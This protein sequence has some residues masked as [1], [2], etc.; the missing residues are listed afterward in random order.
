MPKWSNWSGK[1]PA[2]PQSLYHIRSEE[3]ASAIVAGANTEG[4]TVRIAG[5]GHSHMPLVANDDTILD[6][7]GLAGVIDIDAGA[8]TARV[9][10]GTKIHALGRPLHDA[11]LAL[12]NQGDIDRQAIAGVTATGTHG[13]GRSLGNLSALVTGATLILASGK[14]IDCSAERH[15]ATWAALRLNLGAMGVITQ[16]ELQLR[17]AYKLKESAWNEEFSSLVTRID[18]LAGAHR[19][20][21]FFWSPVDDQAF[22]KT[23]DE[24]NDPVVYPLAE[25]GQRCAWSYEVFP[26]HRPHL[27]TEMEYSVPEEN[28][29]ACFTAIRDLV[30]KDFPDLKWP[31]E[32]R[33]VAADDV[34]LSAAYERAT[35]TISVHQDIREDD[36]P[37]FRA[38]EK[39]FLS[40]GGRPHWGKINYLGGGAMRAVH[41]KWDDWWEIRNKRDPNGI[42]LNDLLRG[43][44]SASS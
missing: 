34:W 7:S 30:H 16:L 37:L 44:Q 17:D 20:F 38:C 39:V 31:V 22:A 32:Y 14:R 5:S 19:H 2:R 12:P 33:T 36:E 8:K 25:E 23:I 35:A 3:D 10:A 1:Y 29:I 21:E 28:G 15:P 26:S 4:R 27:H 42:F 40:F 6:L 11:G 18:E 43:Y 13:T 9:W 41:P 24:T